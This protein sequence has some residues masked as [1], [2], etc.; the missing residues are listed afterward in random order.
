MTAITSHAL[1]PS[2]LRVVPSRD[3]HYFDALLRQPGLYEK[4]TDDATGK[5][6]IISLRD[7]VWNPK[8]HFL[9]V[10]SSDGSSTL[11]HGCF[12]FLVTRFGV[13]DAHV[14]LQESCRGKNAVEAA[15]RAFSWMF[16][17]TDA[18]Q[19][20]TF[21]PDWLKASRVIAYAAGMRKCFRREGM[22]EKNCRPAG[23]TFYSL[24]FYEWIRLNDNGLNHTIQRN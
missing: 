6:G 9:L 23:A 4:L 1:V 19:I 5:C 17:N 10:Q 16:D 2:D 8:H 21:C 15:K 18:F 11:R 20:T 13:Y 14:I 22:F 12:V 24:N 3:W 7:I